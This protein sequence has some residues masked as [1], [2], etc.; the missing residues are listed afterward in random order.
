VAFIERWPDTLS[1]TNAWLLLGILIKNGDYG[2]THRILDKIAAMSELGWQPLIAQRELGHL[3]RTQYEFNRDNFIAS[4]YERL[5]EDERDWYEHHYENDRILDAFLSRDKEFAAFAGVVWK[6][7]KS[8]EIYNWIMRANTY[9][10]RGNKEAAARVLKEMRAQLSTH[11]A[12]AASEA[13]IQ[14]WFS[15]LP[16]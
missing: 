3:E 11:P 5:W 14:S 7:I 10:Q 16:K 15:D 2:V 13:F 8:F 6:P 1:S 9:Y 12:F 4:K